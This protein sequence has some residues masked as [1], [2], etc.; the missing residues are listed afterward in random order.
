MGSHR[1]PTRDRATDVRP[2]P[3]RSDRPSGRLEPRTGA[4]PRLRTGSGTR[5]TTDSPTLRGPR[6][7]PT[8]PTPRLG[9]R[10][11]S[12]F[13]GRPYY[14][15][16]SRYYYGSTHWRGHYSSLSFAFGYTPQWCQ[17]GLYADPFY[18]SISYPRWYF[19]YR[20]A[21]CFAWNGFYPWRASASW[22]WP[23]TTYLPNA[24][25]SLY[26]DGGGSYSTGFRDGWDDGYD[27]GRYYRDR[28][29]GGAVT[30][31]ESTGP[32]GESETITAGPAPESTRRTAAQRHVA[33]GDYYFREERFS[34][35]AESY[36]KA[37]AYAPDDAPLHFVLADALFAT[38]DY[39]YA[40]FIVAKALR[41]DPTLAEAEVDKREFYADATTFDR[42]LETLRGYLGD[43]PYD[44]AAHLLLGYNLRFSGRPTESRKAFER[45]LEI[46]PDDAAAGLFVTALDTPD[47]KAASGSDGRD[48]DE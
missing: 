28:Y 44:S 32:T 37:I 27:E 30:V 41:L 2:T 34:E 15:G 13:R 17:W 9:R 36:L 48:F 25:V 16:P 10:V 42:Q 20:Q 21:R 12:G 46:A 33:L 31:G 7:P 14:G 45:V 3:R 47:R 35:A 40:A 1:Y 39:H 11:G 19:S 18:Y 26:D 8:G 6:R 4:R 43:K 38:G 23:T 5:L 24:Y 29:V 22:W